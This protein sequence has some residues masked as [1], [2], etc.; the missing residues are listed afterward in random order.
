MPY[1]HTSSFSLKSYLQ[2]QVGLELQASDFGCPRG[3]IGQAR[4]CDL[5]YLALHLY[6]GFGFGSVFGFGFD[7]FAVFCFLFLP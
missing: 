6:F 3:Y 2:N 7:V 4:L 5:G 1:F